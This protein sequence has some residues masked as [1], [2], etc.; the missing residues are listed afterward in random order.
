MKKLL[1]NSIVIGGLAGSTLAYGQFD[2][3]SA[4]ESEEQSAFWNGETHTQMMRSH[5][6]SAKRRYTVNSERS[7]SRA[8]EERNERDE[9][10]EEEFIEKMEER[11]KQ[12]WNVREEDLSET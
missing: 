11:H 8:F 9:L 6:H 10:D 5:M 12:M 7:D 1:I 3:V 4:E 2:S